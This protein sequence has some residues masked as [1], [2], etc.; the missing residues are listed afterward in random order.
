MTRDIK[1]LLARIALLASPMVL[2][3]VSYLVVDPFLVLRGHGG[4]YRPNYAVAL[5]RDF[6]STEVYLQHPNRRTFDSF[7]FGSS[8]SFSFRGIDWATYVG[9]RPIFHFDAS[10]ESL[11]GV[12]SK[13]RFLREDGR[14]LRN[15]LLIVDSELLSGTTN[16]RGHLFV[17]DPRVTHEDYVAF[18][19]EF[20]KAFAYPPFL[21]GYALYMHDSV[22]RPWMTGMFDGRRFTHIPATNDLLM[23]SVDEDIAR[24]GEA[25]FDEL[26]ALRRPGPPPGP[27]PPV[28]GDAQRLLL[29]DMRAMI[30][31]DHADC[32]VVISPLF[33]RVPLNPIDVTALRR[34]FGSGNV[35]DFSGANDLTNDVHNYYERS[36]F[37]PFVAQTI[38]RRIYGGT[39]AGSST[40]VER[41]GGGPV[42]SG[43]RIP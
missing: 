29:E 39:A 6:V 12:R 36:H 16:S 33:D 7:I 30:A 21:A 24:K 10:G 35:Y 4:F 41:E 18:H 11:Y 32:R 13:M 2:I 42:R 19:T 1:G 43:S 27:A 9:P 5:N 31:A 40:S 37:R 3:V 14:H 17:H 15:V 28:I 26:R 34:Y 20:I 25:F 22:V 8:R 23:T 38:L